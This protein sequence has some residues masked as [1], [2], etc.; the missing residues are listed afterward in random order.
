MQSIMTR[1]D[2]DPIAIVEPRLYI[3]VRTDIYDMNPGKLGAQTAHAA[4][5]FTMDVL[6][7]EVLE[8]N[9]SKK[10]LNAFNVWEGGRG[11]GTKIT[12]AATESDILGVTYFASGHSQ[13]CDTI[14]DPSYPFRNYFGDVFTSEEL[15]CGYV[16]V[17]E[18][19]P[20]EVLDYLRKFP[21]HK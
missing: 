6:T 10:L 13:V 14:V 5:K 3:I 17:T 21:L 15:T 8:S 11:F 7:S 9:A 12:L 1:K 2:I 18:E 16:F 4:S 20:Q 19:T